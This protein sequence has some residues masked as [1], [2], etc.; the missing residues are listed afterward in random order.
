MKKVLLA[1]V[2]LISTVGYSQ[3]SLEVNKN[4]LK[5]GMEIPLIGHSNMYASQSI[6]SNGFSVRYLRNLF[7]NFSAGV[8]GGGL[9]CNQI[10]D[11]NLPDN[12]LYTYSFKNYYIHA[13]LHYKII[14]NEHFMFAINGS[15]GLGYVDNKAKQITYTTG[16]NILTHEGTLTEKGKTFHYLLGAETAYR[17][18]KNMSANLEY[19][20][21]IKHTNHIIGIGI[22]YSF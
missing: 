8:A 20:F 14:N 22:N 9:F 19:K 21:D 16:S 3:N 7:G 13:M 6:V 12:T 1:V 15:A 2:L 18:T 11:K 5:I 10:G 17:F 4:E